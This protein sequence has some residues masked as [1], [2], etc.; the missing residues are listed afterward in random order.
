MKIALAVLIL[1]LVLIPVGLLIAS[2]TPAVH[3]DPAVHVLGDETP[4]KVR[5]SATHGARR[6][7]AYIEQ[8]N[9]RY[10]VFEA[11]QPASR[12]MFW[13]KSVPA[14]E[15]VFPAGKKRAPSIQ[16]GKAR[17]I[18]EAVSNDL[19]GSEAVG[20]SDIEINTRPL[21]LTVDGAQHYVNQG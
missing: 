14:S 1:I 3:I 9:Q 17:L 15:L 11:T 16:D 21:S 12:F 7:T 6:V 13:R 19:R 20:A 5:V 8:N 10:Q 18:V 4:V 2:S